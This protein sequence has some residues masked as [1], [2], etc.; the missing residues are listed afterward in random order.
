MVESAIKII[1]VLVDTVHQVSDTVLDVDCRVTQ[2]LKSN[3]ELS[4]DLESLLVIV[5][6]PDRLPHVEVLDLGLIGGR[7]NIA[8]IG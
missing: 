8:L 3:H 5:L 7:R 6:L 1:S 4:L 2:G